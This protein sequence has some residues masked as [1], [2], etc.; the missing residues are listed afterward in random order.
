MK[1]IAI[2]TD[3]GS[4]GNPGPGGYAAI[5]VHG[6]RRRELSGGFR[7]TTNNRMEILAAIGAL[8]V[9]KQPCA[10]TLY[11]DSR[12]LV[13]A[14]SKGW[15]AGWKK[16]GWKRAGNERLKNADLWQ[17]LERAAAS[18]HMTW[19]W[20]KGHAGHREN[21]RC[22]ELVGIAA[23]SPGLPNDEGYLRECGHEDGS[24]RSLPQ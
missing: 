8:E 19:K 10:I 21:E 6:A 1:E 18:H 11:S 9:L 23:R 12:Y 24:N 13:D 16:R 7:R 3:G 14:M 22:D 2:Y 17:R 20:V 5:L 15:L 4:K